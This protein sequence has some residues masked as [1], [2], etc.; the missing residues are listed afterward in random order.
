MGQHHRIAALQRLVTEET[1]PLRVRDVTQIVRLTI[2]DVSQDE[3][4]TTLRLGNLPTPVP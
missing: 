3:G 2:D 1:L 4:H